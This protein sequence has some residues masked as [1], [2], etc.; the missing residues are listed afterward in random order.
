VSQG[1]A[2]GVG[3]HVGSGAT[4][5]PATP[6]STV[7]GAAASPGVACGAGD[8]FGHGKVILLGEHAV[9]YGYPALA[10]GLSRGMRAVARPGAG[11]LEV[12]EWSLDLSAQQD[13]RDAAAGHATRA[14]DADAPADLG[15]SVSGGN[16]VSVGGVAAPAG[17]AAS[18]VARV[19]RA[20][21]AILDGLG[22]HAVDVTVKGDLPAQAGLGS[23]AAFSCAVAFAVARAHGLPRARALAAAHLGE[24]VFHGTPSGIDLAAA[25]TGAVGR[26]ERGPGWTDVRVHQPITLCVGLSGRPHATH[27]LVEGVRRLR[28]RTP[29]V[30]RVI[31][32]LGSMA[33]AGE[34]ALGLGHV[35]ELG[36]LFDVAHGLLSALRLSSPE[37]ETLVH[38]ARRAGAIGAKLTGAGGGG[39]VIALA[40]GNESS[41]L[42]AW[43]RDGF[44]GFTATVAGARADT[45]ASPEVET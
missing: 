39:A 25:S 28:E 43:R 24:V 21:S 17:P 4:G 45:G 18:D 29:V 16:G 36:R 10:A 19:A 42:A 20:W 35:D 8:G 1:V 23:S 22:V 37:L 14:V 5:A 38:G 9:V 13:R 6:T 27:D 32:A 33:S 26:F 7:P 11:R 30:A 34:A 12:P 15:V 3:D 40:P 41:V 31:E 2:G 44:D